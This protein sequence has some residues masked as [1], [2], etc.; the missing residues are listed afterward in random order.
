MQPRVLLVD[1]EPHVTEALKRVIRE[2][3][4]DIRTASSARTALQILARETDPELHQGVIGDL[5]DS[6]DAD[7]SHP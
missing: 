1:D 2:E 6:H 7:A 5:N 3:A 4:Y